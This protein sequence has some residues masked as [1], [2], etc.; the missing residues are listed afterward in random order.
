MKRLTIHNAIIGL[1]ILLVASRL[2]VIVDGIRL[3][4]VALFELFFFSK[5]VIAKLD[6]ET[7]DLFIS[8][9]LILITPILYFLIYRKLKLFKVKLRLSYF[10]FLLL[11][12]AFLFAPIIT[13]FHPNAQ[14]NI[15]GGRFLPPFSSMYAVNL[16]V[17]A[18]NSFD[19]IKNEV[20]KYPVIK[21]TIYANTVKM[22]GD[23]IIYKQGKEE[24]KIKKSAAK[25]ID[26]K[27]VIIKKYFLFGTDE[28]SRDV[29]SRIIFGGRISLFIAVLT[30]AIS[31]SLGLL[32]GFL[33]SF[34]GGV[35][36][37][38]LSRFTDM[39][40]TIPSIFF[41]IMVL[42]LWGNSILGVIVVLALTGWMGF[43]KVVKV[44]VAS[45]VQKDYF[46]TSKKIGMSLGK[47]LAKEIL[48]VI[49]SQIIVASV[50]QFSNVILAEASLSYLGLGVGINYPSWG[51]MILSGQQYMVND[52]WLI[53]IPS[54]VLVL[55][56]LAINDFGEKL[57]EELSPWIA[58]DK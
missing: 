3:L 25:L 45:I 54:I 44:E 41:V 2:T 49:L 39:F 18:G 52:V 48:P 43:F 37:L 12:F 10:V 4:G 56:I 6:S 51:N 24:K 13:D 47:L 50:L 14:P 34:F 20:V 23:Y 26:G 15:N 40:L 57:K 17:K 7:L 42:A 55:S 21:N 58:R 31:L 30:V 1:F 16:K 36:N 29:F 9:I 28:L 35:L 46:I 32:L 33:A 38:L 53:I 19:K 11:L 8:I 5:V 22:K 27:P